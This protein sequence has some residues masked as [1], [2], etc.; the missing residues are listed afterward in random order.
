MIFL[1]AVWNILQTGG[2][3]AESRGLMV[4]PMFDLYTLTHVNPGWPASPVAEDRAV[5]SANYGLEADAW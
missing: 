5:T 1:F 3:L 4:T 2:Q